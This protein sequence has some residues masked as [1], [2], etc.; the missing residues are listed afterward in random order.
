MERAVAEWERF[1]LAS[2]WRGV[3]VEDR[4]GGYPSGQRGLTVN[5][6]AYAFGGSNPSPP[7]SLSCAEHWECVEEAQGLSCTKHWECVDE[8]QGLSCANR[9]GDWRRIRPHSSVGRARSW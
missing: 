1:A 2:K 6:L 5:Q 3:G 7:T 4:E 8:A 9:L